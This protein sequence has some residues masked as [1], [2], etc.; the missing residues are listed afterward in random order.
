M[1]RG[2]LFVNDSQKV[3]ES[4]QLVKRDGYYHLFFTEEGEQLVSHI[5]SPSFT[6]GWSK[7][8]RSYIDEGHA[9][10]VTTLP[11]EPELWSLHRGI[12]LRDGTRFFFRFG[13]IG[14]DEPGGA[15][16][17]SYA[18]GFA[19]NWTIV[20]G[21]AFSYQP[22]WGDNPYERYGVPTGM[23]GNSYVATYEFFPNPNIYPPGRI[24][25]NA[26][27]GLLRSDDF[28]VTGDRLSL[29]VGGGNQPG[30]T[31]VAMVGASS[32]RVL[33]WETGADAHQLTPRLWN[34]SSLI[35][36]TV[37]LVIADLSTEA[38]GHI[39]V[40]SIEEYLLS[41]QD[42]QPPSTPMTDG[43]YLAQVLHDAGFGV[44]AAPPAAPAPAGRLL[45][46]YPNPFNPSTRLRY[47]LHA[48]GRAELAILDAQGRSLRRLL[49]AAL[50][51]G[52]GFVAWD[53]RD[54][55]GHS[56]PSGLYFARLALDGREVGRQKLLLVK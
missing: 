23:E 13:T 42:P 4:V 5:A 55:Q 37:Y 2:A 17:V 39:A 10:E 36:Q 16:S 45:A 56:L 46:P 26:P 41:G 1:D 44:S 38:W 21:D 50:P 25:G 30:L 28:T 20:F 27:T 31:F 47:E 14:F 24:Q 22:T 8:N 29:L 9:C 7:D 34:L 43:P 35:G 33:L 32:G 40:D 51:A 6:G 53:G 11:G 48:G 12:E 15:P 52:P 18:D 54:A 49:D 3:L 19:D